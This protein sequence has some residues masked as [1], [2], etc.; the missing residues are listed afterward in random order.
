MRYLLLV[1]LL[2]LLFN[3]ES[4]LAQNSIDKK[5]GQAKKIET[6]PRIDGI[7]DDVCWT[8]SEIF[9]D[10]RQYEPFS[11]EA[12]RLKTEVRIVYNDEAIFVCAIN[13]DHAPDSIRTQLGPRDGDRSIIADYFNIDIVPY[14]DGIN[15]YSFKLSASGVQSDIKRSSG[16]GGRDLNWDAVW[17][18][19]VRIT[20]DGW[21]AEFKIPFSAIR[22]PAD[23]KEAWGINFWR[24]IQ[25]YGEWS[26]WNFADK[27]YGTTINYM[28]EVDGI[29][30]LKPP[31]RI[32]LTPYVSGHMERNGESEAWS[33]AFHG[34][35]DLKVGLSESFTLDATLIPDFKQVRS[36]DQVL[37]LSP[38]EVKYNERRQFFTE[39]TDV[40]KE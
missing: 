38:Y 14:N 20:E 4:V 6:A 12:S 31:A 35:A 10:F 39:G 26:S 3:T 1:F 25:R 2:L 34:G 5:Q 23:S 37:N 17:H 36:D 30:E 32:S 40:F 9:T 28:G 27:S 21:I 8:E 19:A 13:F 22:F 15:G 24:Y 18:S 7:Q 33:R 11:G 29:N 16:A